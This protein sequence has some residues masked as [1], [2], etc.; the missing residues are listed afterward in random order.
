VIAALT[1]AV[2]E[3]DINIHEAASDSL[4]RL[5]DLRPL[6]IQQIAASA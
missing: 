4:T 1:K 5:R 6:S 2:Q 3:G